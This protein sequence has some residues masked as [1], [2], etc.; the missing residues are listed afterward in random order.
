MTKEERIARANVLKNIV[1]DEFYQDALESIRLKL[2]DKFEQ[3]KPAEHEK[4]ES[5][6]RSLT[7]LKVLNSTLETAIAEGDVAKKHIDALANNGVKNFF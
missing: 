5:I 3:S 6:H 2:L 1:E 7:L 4:R